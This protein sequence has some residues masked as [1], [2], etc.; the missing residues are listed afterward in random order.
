MIQI[1]DYTWYQNENDFKY[2]NIHTLL[3]NDLLK[4]IVLVY[5]ILNIFPF[6][7]G[8]L[9]FEKNVSNKI[10]TSLSFIVVSSVSSQLV[11][12]KIQH[13]KLINPLMISLW[14][15]FLLLL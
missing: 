15:S 13:K 10:L 5:C 8:V 12:F 6:G 7:I 1:Y 14:F 9:D 11:K 2:R 4:Y 3:K